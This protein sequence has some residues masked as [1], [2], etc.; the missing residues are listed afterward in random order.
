[1]ADISQIVQVS[2]SSTPAAVTQEGFGIGLVLGTH[3]HSTAR[4]Q[5][6]ASLAALLAVH[7]STSEVGKA[8]AAYFAQSP[9]PI[10]MAVGRR[11]VNTCTVVVDTATNSV[12]YTLTVN[13]TAY[14]ITSD[15]SATTAEIATALR[16]AINADSPLPVTASGSGAN[17]ILTAD[18]SG[19][20]FSL[21]ITGTKMSL[22]ALVAADTI[23]NDLTAVQL[24]NR[25]WYG[26]ILTDRASAD[27]QAAMAWVAAVP[28][29]LFAQTQEA[30][31]V[32]VADSSDSAT[33]GAIF[34]DAA[35]D[36]AFVMYHASANTVYPDAAAAGR[37]LP[38]VPGSYTAKFKTLTGIA[39]SSLTETQEANALDKKVNIQESIGGRNIVRNGTVSS[40]RFLDQVHGQDWLTARIEEAVFDILSSVEKVPFTDAGIA[41]IEN[42]MKGPLQDA[43][44][45]GYLASFTTSVPKAADV[46]STNKGN[47]LLPDVKFTA[48]E[49]GAIHAVT[50]NG[51]ISV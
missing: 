9:A 32:D 14:T 10:G 46:S 33:L 11:Q 20:A 36:R 6:F 24:E 39:V 21:A 4:Y 1:M 8:A 45:N 43:I 37:Y 17:V 34:E 35:Q 13:G 30:N 50:I 19:V 26:V 15:S 41:M 49:A 5:I 18:V 47:R 29:I 42:A 16:A 22:S 7:G 12:D 28:K 51:T 44:D 31:T 2:I 3:I 27:A 23:A 48:V 38:K 25:D 40:G